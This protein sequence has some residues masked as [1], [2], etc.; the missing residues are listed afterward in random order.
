M[1]ANLV[2]S[3]MKKKDV[4]NKSAKEIKVSTT[5][6]FFLMVIIYSNQFSVHN[7]L[8]QGVIFL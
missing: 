5:I 1:A 2:H 8:G 7:G 6:V 4:S 3:N